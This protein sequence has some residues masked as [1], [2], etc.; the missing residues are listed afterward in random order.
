M[1]T[2]DAV[3]QLRVNCAFIGTSG[4]AA[5]GHIMDSTLVEVPVN[6]ALVTTARE[7]VAVDDSHKIAGSVLG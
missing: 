4:V 5:G 3:S 7:V 6:R 2:Q 1:L